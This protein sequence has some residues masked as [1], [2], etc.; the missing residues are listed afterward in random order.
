MFAAVQL[1]FA[2]LRLRK[3]WLIMQ[4]NQLRLGFSQSR[5]LEWYLQFTFLNCK[6]WGPEHHFSVS[7]ILT[8]SLYQ[9]TAR[10]I[11]TNCI[12]KYRSN[13]EWTSFKRSLHTMKLSCPCWNELAMG[14]F[15]FAD[16]GQPNCII[17]LV[18]LLWILD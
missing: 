14:F 7:E 8:A 10:Q 6:I 4:C 16:L 9:L 12:S 13:E 18:S 2:R 11:T 15:C 17:Y 5:L 3:I 1:D